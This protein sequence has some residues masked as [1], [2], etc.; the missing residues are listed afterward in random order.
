MKCHCLY[1]APGNW[2]FI[3]FRFCVLDIYVTQHET[4]L[5]PT[6]SPPAVICQESVLVRCMNTVWMSS[7]RITTSLWTQAFL[8]ACGWDGCR[9]TSS[10]MWPDVSAVR[11]CSFPVGCSRFS[12]ILICKQLIQAPLKP[13][14]TSCE[15]GSGSQPIRFIKSVVQTSFY[16]RFIYIPQVEFISLHW[17]L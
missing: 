8:C 14:L 13:P 10:Q 16:N 15:I 6:A 5:N 7:S 1:S 17:L 4:Q 2:I 3:T 9:N 11:I 12:E